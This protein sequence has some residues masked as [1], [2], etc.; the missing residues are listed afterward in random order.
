MVT[1]RDFVWAA[2]CAA[3]LASC[4]LGTTAGA[5]NLLAN[6]GFED[7]PYGSQTVP[8]WTNWSTDLSSW[9]YYDG[10]FDASWQSPPEQPGWPSNYGPHGGTYYLGRYYRPADPS[11]GWLK[12]A[13]YQ[14]FTDRTPGETLYG[15]C[16]IAAHHPHGA[17]AG[18]GVRIGLDPAFD[19]AVDTGPTDEV[20]WDPPK[21]VQG[22][23]VF[24]FFESA[25]G[26]IQTSA[27]VGGAGS[28]TLWLQYSMADNNI[29]EPQ[30]VHVDDARLATTK[31][32]EINN[33]M[34][35]GLTSTMAKI[36]F[37][38]YDGLQSLSTSGY[39]DYGATSAYGTTRADSSN[40]RA[41]HEVLLTGLTANA[42]YHFRCRAQAADYEE[43]VTADMTF[44]MRPS[45]KIVNVQ[46]T[47]TTDTTATIEWDTQDPVSP[48][49]PVAADS[50]VEY[51]YTSTSFV[52]SQYD[53]TP[54]T[55][56][57]ITLTG[58]NPN[59]RYYYRV[60]SAASDYNPN[61]Y[62]TPPTTV[63]FMTDPGEFWNGGFE[64]VLTEPR[65][66]NDD[67]P[68]W[69]K[70]S[71]RTQWFNTGEWE[72]PSHGGDYYI[73][74]V[75][76]FDLK[77]GTIL[78]RFATTP[79][80][81]LSFSAWIWA[82]STG[83]WKQEGC[84]GIPHRFGESVGLIGIDPL[85]G[86]DEF[87]QDIVWSAERQTQDWR[88]YMAGDPCVKH[89]AGWQKVGVSTIDPDGG[90][91]TIFLKTHIWWPVGWTYV[92]FDDVGPEPEAVVG[93]VAEAKTK[94]NDTAIDLHAAT[95]AACPVVT[96]IANP[97]PDSSDNEALPYFYVEDDSRSAGI[98]VTM[99]PGAEWPADLAVGKR[100]KIR[101]CITWGQMRNRLYSSM[102]MDQQL[103]LDKPAGERVI[104][105]YQVTVTGETGSVAPLGMGSRGI[106]GGSS[107]D[108]WLTN[109][110]AADATGEH[111]V[112]LLVR[113]WGRITA[114]HMDLNG[115]YIVIDDGSG[116]AAYSGDDSSRTMPDPYPT[117][118][119]VYTADDYSAE[120]GKYAI[121]TGISGVKIDYDWDDPSYIPG[122]HMPEAMKNARLLKAADI[123][124]LDE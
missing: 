122:S 58:L 80:Q 102:R 105:A 3:V 120:V 117:G 10:V 70:I 38:T 25:Y 51:G 23:D 95:D 107:S 81:V 87:S 64:T 123:Q 118:L 68:G 14:R 1:G 12:G 27:A 72:L 18:C 62:P 53:P 31:S 76:N 101:G 52:F 17:A 99:A 35:V 45:V 8:G 112:G 91:A 65:N 11:T 5:E 2:L 75:T 16:W 93:S 92:V 40:P 71:G 113:T 20:V 82:E 119:W 13:V 86:I 61:R 96:Y 34:V 60:S 15:Q 106:A 90:E 7:P 32:M 100:V 21:D 56:H 104:R 33:V 84:P 48:Y 4:W 124:I 44:V 89:A 94:P 79:G 43:A 55:H 26:K 46:V 109:P 41:G 98:K 77:N 88:A 47:D 6:P 114:A 29:S 63:S 97:N 54:V 85:G 74:S 19:P 110:G 115:Y 116:A 22:R 28:M 42:T 49:P 24:G 103:R 78:Q 59:T 37:D 108:A 111:T 67:I 39:V 73:G 50:K 30:I 69:T 83:D 66:I 57:V 121:V 9:H 36:A